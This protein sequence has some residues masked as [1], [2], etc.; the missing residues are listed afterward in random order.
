MTTLQKLQQLNQI[1]LQ[2]IKL[3]TELGAS[4][5]DVGYTSAAID[6]TKRKA[7]R[8]VGEEAAQAEAKNI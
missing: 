1:Q 6:R 8:K 4:S 3:M 7:Q 5:T 2:L